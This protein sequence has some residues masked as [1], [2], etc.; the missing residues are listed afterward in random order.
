[1]ERVTEE[2]LRNMPKAEL[3]LHLEGSLQPD[4]AFNLAK[5][6]N[7]K[8][9]SEN[10]P[11]QTAEALKQSYNFSGLASFLDVYYKVSQVFIH[12]EDFYDL[13]MEYCKNA[14]HENVKHVEAFFDPQTHT[15]RNIPFKTVADGIN[16]ALK[17]AR[18]KYGISS[19]LIMCILRDLS[20]GTSDQNANYKKGFENASEATAWKTLKQCIQYNNNLQNPGY[21]IIGIG[22][23][24]NEVGYPQEL[25]TELY[26][27]A[28]ANDLIPTSHAGEEGPISNIQNAIEMLQCVRIDHGIKITANPNLMEKFG[29]E[30]TNTNIPKAYHCQ[31][32]KIP[33]TVCPLSNYK[34]KVFAD[35]HKTNILQMLDAGI[36]CTVCSDDPAFFGG[37][38]TENYLGLIDWLGPQNT[39]YRPITL[40]DIKQLCIN[41]FEASWLPPSEKQQH[42]TDVNQYFQEEAAD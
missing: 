24:S 18:K 10:F 13:T 2:F 35:P 25:F 38:I 41:S 1:M 16:K 4:L 8:L 33:F 17:D 20:L 14:K 6:N 21:K 39:E 31:Y 29:R 37:F 15:A 12:E 32:H 28:T 23:D 42:I 9:D 11:W 36:Q 5:R 40:P 3:H 22:L 30:L 26:G 7:I 34:L 27:Y 19:R